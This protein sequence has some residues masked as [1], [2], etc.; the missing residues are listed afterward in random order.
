MKKEDGSNSGYGFVC[1]EDPESATRAVNDLNGKEGLYV[2][3]ALKKQQR[4][5][6]V[7][8][9]SEKFKKSMQKF[10]LYVKNVPLDTTDLELKEFF[11]KFGEVNNV[12]IMKKQKI[13][14]I[15]QTTEP[16]D[17]DK[18]KKAEEF[19]SLG[20]GFVSYTS[21]ESAAR[22]KLET[23]SQPFRGVILFVCQ[24]ETKAV[25]EAHLAETRDKR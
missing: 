25:R 1:Y 14:Q 19:E 11:S 4:M 10:N 7:K 18:E 9:L 24:F 2:R 5:A 16:T 15:T 17:G 12:R 13:T 8:K 23:K 20:F 3:R 6:E 22:A 21:A